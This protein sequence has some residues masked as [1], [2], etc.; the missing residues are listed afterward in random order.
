MFE[1][2]FEKYE[3]TWVKIRTKNFILKNSLK[4]LTY[5]NYANLNLGYKG[6]T[7]LV[8]YSHRPKLLECFDW[9]TNIK[10]SMKNL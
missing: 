9:N 5:V 6:L 8:L 7:Y 4:I 10:E 1:S 2:T 3:I